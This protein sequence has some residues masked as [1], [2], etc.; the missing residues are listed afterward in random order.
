F[1]IMHSRDLIH[2]EVISNVVSPTWSG[3]VGQDGPK[4][5]TWQGALAYFDKK[6]WAFFFIHGGGQYFSNASS[7][8]GPWTTPTLV[9]G[10]IGYDNAVFVDDNDRAY[11]LMKNGQDL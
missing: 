1:P 2:W 9:R 5:G 7:P 10:S 6:F 11:M 3:L 8:E 4:D